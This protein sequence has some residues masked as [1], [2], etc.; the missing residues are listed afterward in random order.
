MINTNKIRHFSEEEIKEAQN[1]FK[2][3]KTMSKKGE[4]F[5]YDYLESD[6]FQKFA[7][8]IASQLYFIFPTAHT[9]ND[10]TNITD[11]LDTPMNF[12]NANAEGGFSFFLFSKDGPNYALKQ[13]FES[14][15]LDNHFSFIGD[16]NIMALPESDITIKETIDLL[17]SLGIQYYLNPANKYIAFLNEE[18]S[19]YVEKKNLD[20]GMSEPINKKDTYKL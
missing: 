16:N 20:A 17:L 7:Y 12:K 4:S 15:G 6:S 5:F 2:N 18:I 13:I 14:M 11:Y 8:T 1:I 9:D 10:K 19:I 3:I